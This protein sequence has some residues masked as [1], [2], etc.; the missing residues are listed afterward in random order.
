MKT[1]QRLLSGFVL[2]SF[3]LAALAVAQSGSSRK[4][5]LIRDTGEEE[6][7]K[8]AKAQESK[9]RNPMLAEENVGIGNFYFKRK[10]YIA[11]IDRYLLALEYQPDSI[12]AH[13]A[14]GR[15]YEKNGDI[16]KAVDLYTRFIEE[17]PNSPKSKEFRAKVA[18]LQKYGVISPQQP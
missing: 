11:A 16:S 13:E 12:K 14:L 3:S 18:K 17:N 6:E 7:Q 1:I 8:S 15:A 10:N 2:L 9:E 5:E 4:P